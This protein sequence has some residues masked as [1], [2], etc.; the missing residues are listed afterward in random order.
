MSETQ[1]L[2][3]ETLTTD[4]STASANTEVGTS[5][6]VAAPVEEQVTAS[7]ETA[8]TE[9]PAATPTPTPALQPRNIAEIR[10]AL[11]DPNAT[12]TGAEIQT[13][14]RYEQSARDMQAN[15][16]ARRNEFTNALTAAQELALSH[17]QTELTNALARDREPDLDLIREKLA[18]VFATVEQKA[19]P[20]AVARLDA[21]ADR[22]LL[23]F[24]G[25]DH[26]A[27]SEAT[28]GLN[29]RQ[30]IDLQ[31]RLAYDMGRRAGPEEGSIVLTQAELDA[32]IKAAV[33]GSRAAT[34][35]NGTSVGAG[36]ASMTGAGITINSKREARD[37]HARD[38]LSN[39]QMKRINADP[40]IPEGY[41]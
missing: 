1:T 15:V 40:S 21:D 5:T 34:P 38:M 22:T 2:E 19:E 36:A 37:L 35:Q 6:E 31:N 20:A 28:K 7:T 25:G 32:R 26:M 23:E 13:L 18:S 24:Y 29:I 17:V 4:T 41:F 14:S 39:D 10:A 27:F 30:K 3:P 16:E 12:V 8:S 11:A 9:T 33:N